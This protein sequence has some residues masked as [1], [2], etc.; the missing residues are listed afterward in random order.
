MRAHRFVGVL[1]LACACAGR[2]SSPGA[3]QVRPGIEVVLS[4]SAHLIAGKR[5]GLL[6]NHTGID[7]LG[8]RD[9]DLLL[10]VRGGR[11]T[12]LFSPEHGFRG[13]EDREGLPDGRDSATGLPIYSLYGGSRSAARAA[14]D[15]IDVVL[16]DL[17]DIG[18][19]YYTYPATAASLM[20]DA[21]KAGKPVIILDRPIPVGGMAVQ[22]NVRARLADPDSN[23][24]SF[25]PVAMR[26]GM[27]LGELA[28]M[29]ND[30]MELKLDL[31]VVPAQGWQRSQFYDET[32]LPWIKPSPNMPSLESAML[33]PGLCLFEG[34][35][36]SVGRGT[37][38]AFQVLGAPWLDPAK[39][40]ER[41]RSFQVAGVEVVDTTF[42]P[43]APTDGKYPGVALPGIRMRVTDRERFDPTRFAVVLLAAL[44]S[45]HPDRFEFRASQFDRLAAGPDLRL[46]IEAGRSPREIWES[47]EPE[48]ARFREMR[49]KYL[50]Y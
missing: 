21:S 37:P 41:L 46:A 13:T 11:L 7:H 8:R 25:L 26:H 22:G 40:S 27:T 15:S 31:T 6:T 23:L 14:L 24:V 28:N 47:W 50:I 17:Q 29:A 18:A 1:S 32:G 34:T 2:G 12:V 49:R 5:L 30:L 45:T 3:T 44:R 4:D 48:L 20:R 33:Y 43:L 36:L 10:A 16:I 38:I 35:N 9:A 19:R 42:T 39:L